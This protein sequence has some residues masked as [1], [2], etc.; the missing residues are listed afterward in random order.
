MQRLQIAL[1]SLRYQHAALTKAMSVVPYPESS[2]PASRGSPLLPSTAE[3]VSNSPQSS[4]ATIGKLSHRMSAYSVHSD[5][6]VWYDAPEFD[7]AEEFVLD[8]TPGEETQGSQLSYV[9]SP[10]LMEEED[11]I[12]ETESGSEMAEEELRRAMSPTPGMVNG[13]AISRRLE[14]P[15]PPVGDEGSLFAV[16]KKNVGKVGGTNIFSD[17]KSD[18]H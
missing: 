10:T 14:L 12:T 9:D 3:E 8:G 2:A 15:S 17:L 16:L 7:G 6:S 11:E 5:G 1:N 18:L 13:E 4:Y